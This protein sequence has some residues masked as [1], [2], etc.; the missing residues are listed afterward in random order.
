MLE[1]ISYLHLQKIA[2]RDLK[3][4]NFLFLKEKSNVIKLID[5]GLARRWKESL[6][7]DL[8]SETGQIVGTV[9][10]IGCSLTI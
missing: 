9:S 2:H 5:F 1:A 6:S 8:L 4:E 10:F 3:P 7:K